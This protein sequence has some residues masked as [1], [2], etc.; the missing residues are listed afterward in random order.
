MMRKLQ[1]QSELKSFTRDFDRQLD[2]AITFFA[3]LAVKARLRAQIRLAESIL[4]RS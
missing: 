2:G 1:T 3:P 4:A